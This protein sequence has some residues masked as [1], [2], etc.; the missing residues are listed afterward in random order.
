MTTDWAAHLT[1]QV[2]PWW[3]E[4]GV[5]DE[6]GGVRTGFDN[7]GA[8]HTT[9]RFTWSQGRWAWLA[10]ELHD[11]SVSGRLTADADRWA[12]RCVL[13][14]DRIVT[15]AIRPDGRTHF[16]VRE[17]GTPVSNDSG[18]AATS[19]FADLFA[20]LG[21]AGGLR[22]VSDADPRHGVWL[23]SALRVLTTARA[24]VASG[25]A[26]SDPY[27]VP[28]G[29]R[30]LAGPMTLLHTASELLR[31]QLPPEA[32]KQA[33]D[34][35]DWA[36]AR[37]R[38]THLTD[39]GWWEFAPEASEMSDTLLARHRTPGHLL[40][41]LWMIRHAQEQDQTFRLLTPEASTRL[42]RQAIEMSWDT[43]FGGM[44]RYTDYTGGEP[45]GR[46]VNTPYEDLVRQ[47][48]STKLWWVHVEATYSLAMH[49][50][51][52]VG[53]ELSPW[54][55]RVAAWTWGTFPGPPGCEWVQIRDRSGV[56]LN[57]VVALPVKDPFHIIRA[58]IFMNR[59]TSV[60]H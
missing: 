1:Q 37:I 39:D 51:D 23:Q 28:S 29:F 42:A 5:D 14:C 56:P 19:V 4:R 45:A 6:R 27:P 46:L 13:T 21:L 32:A 16:R 54:A 31:A 60:E 8:L 43:D 48:W 38:Q 26:P 33:R 34:A 44:L 15:E 49:A 57:Q 36:A 24:A 10:A 41:L 20:V 40:E 25:K 22:V 58:L 55:D 35:R 9:D 52:A 18:E 2:L 59:L 47:T 7:S 30:D 11:E 17:D 50:A 12:R 53:H 3:E